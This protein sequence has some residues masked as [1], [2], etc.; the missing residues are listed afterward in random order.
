MRKGK[1]KTGFEFE[2]DERLLDD[3]RV[4]DLLSEILDDGSSEIQIVSASS[5]LINVLLGKDLKNA[6]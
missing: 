1:T 3:M 2:Y 5:K 4:L 6:L